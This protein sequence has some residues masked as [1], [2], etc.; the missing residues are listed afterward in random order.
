[1]KIKADTTC[2]W[3]ISDIYQFQFSQKLIKHIRAGEAFTLPGNGRNMQSND[4]QDI[5]YYYY[6]FILS[7]EGKDILM[8]PPLAASVISIAA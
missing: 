3:Q 7:G 5:F 4:E 6:Y 2:A 1:M 8:S